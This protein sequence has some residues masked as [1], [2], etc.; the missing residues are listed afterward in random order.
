ML[1]LSREILPYS[2]EISL[3]EDIL[4]KIYYKILAGHENSCAYGKRMVALPMIAIRDQLF[5]PSDK[6][7][8][9]TCTQQFTWK[10]LQSIFNHF[11]RDI[12]KMKF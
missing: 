4:L 1:N 3:A 9:F 2:R 7:S 5:K 6:Y 10:K 12:V 11:F 8:I